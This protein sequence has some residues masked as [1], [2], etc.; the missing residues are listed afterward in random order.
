MQAVRLT[1]FLASR[2][3]ALWAGGR[4]VACILAI[5]A[6]QPAASQV[7][8]YAHIDETPWSAGN[9]AAQIDAG[10]TLYWSLYDINQQ[11]RSGRAVDFLLLSGT[12]AT[13]SAHVAITNGVLADTILVAPADGLLG[14]LPSTSSF[15]KQIKDLS[16][17]A[18]ME[19]NVQISLLRLPAGA[20]GRINYTLQQ[21]AALPMGPEG[22]LAFVCAPDPLTDLPKAFARN[23]TLAEWSALYFFQ[24]CL[25]LWRRNPHNQLANK[26]RNMMPL[27]QTRDGGYRIVTLPADGSA[28]ITE[29]GW[30]GEASQTE[31]PADKMGDLVLAEALEE[32]GRLEESQAKFESALASKDMAVRSRATSGIDRVLHQRAAWTWWSR[33]ILVA[34]VILPF[35]VAHFWLRR[36]RGRMVLHVEDLVASGARADFVMH[37]QRQ[38]RALAEVIGESFLT[39]TDDA[40]RTVFA[41][42]PSQTLNLSALPGLSVSKVDVKSVLV[43]VQVFAEY[44]SRRRLVVWVGTLSKRVMIRAAIE[45]GWT[46]Q[47]DWAFEADTDEEAAWQLVTW[48]A[49]YDVTR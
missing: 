30:P 10:F 19:K 20:A 13:V 17:G 48:A 31:L 49:G 29:R 5:W 3:R 12:A 16:A 4:I 45:S 40:E 26:K 41:P 2:W 38:E 11:M 15:S 27:E 9:P 39:G 42:P 33:L 23:P 35:A 44:F 7:L 22:A 37:V 28:V 1:G 24:N 43:W 46:R 47:N 6:V 21:I 8:S 18:A 14:A 36:R 32:H 34:A 25:A